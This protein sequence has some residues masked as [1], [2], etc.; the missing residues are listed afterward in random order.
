MK[1]LPLQLFALVCL[2]MTIVY[3]LEPPL[4]PQ[5]FTQDFVQGDDITEIYTTGKIWY[6]I[7]NDRQRCDVKSN[8]YDLIC[9]SVSL[10]LN[11]SC[12]QI[13]KNGTLYIMLPQSNQC[14]KCCTKQQGCGI[15]PR[16]WL[17]DYEYVGIVPMLGWAYY[18]AWT[19]YETPVNQ[20][21]YATPDERQVP[22]KM[23][24][25]SYGV[26]FLVPSYT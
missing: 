24:Y 20:T 21:Y 16:D 23:E 6:D 12:S 15:T 26:N 18:N 2:S 13:T 25:G 11:A 8:Y 19:N 1:S 3:C 9:Q 5:T 14:C 4:W 10:K 22:K 17:K 7:K